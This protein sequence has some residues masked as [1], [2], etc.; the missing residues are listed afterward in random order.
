MDPESSLRISRPLY[1]TFPFALHVPVLISVILAFLI[2]TPVTLLAKLVNDAVVS[3][4]AAGIPESAG[5]CR[6]RRLSRTSQLG[7]LL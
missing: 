1:D 6:R 5:S 3:E 7:P 2:L 4:P